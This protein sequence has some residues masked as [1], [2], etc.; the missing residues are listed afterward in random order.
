[1][2]EMSLFVKEKSQY[3]Y[4]CLWDMS[5]SRVFEVTTMMTPFKQIQSHPD[6]C[7]HCEHRHVRLFCNL[8]QD[9]LEEFD[10]IGVLVSHAPGAKL[11]AEGDVARNI[12]VLCS[13]QV[14]LSTTS[15]DG[16]TMILKIAVAGDLLGLNAALA[17][18]PHEV[19]AE[20][21]EPCTI[22]TVRR[23]QFVDLLQSHGTASM[24]AAQS[25]SLEYGAVF[26]DA[27]RL[28]LST[29]AGGRLAQLLLE[30]ARASRCGESEMK[31]TM[32]LTH[33]EIA[34]MAGTSR[35]TVTRLLNQFRR[36]QWIRIH[37]SRVTILNE[38]ELDKLT[39]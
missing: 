10:R 24:K 33:E 16:R 8:P 13:G 6:D 2:I 15:R 30:W 4:A 28:A 9:A 36:Q 25:L 21:I 32:A 3:T 22:K 5:L 19:T 12:F 23:E 27:R 35:E 34:N 37:G 11:F 39:A 1:M 20:T 7:V 38:A 17:D 14:K 26:R 29:T 18:T 31:F